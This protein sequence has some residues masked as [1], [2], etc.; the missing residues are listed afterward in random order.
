MSA[1]DQ[2]LPDSFQKMEH[3]LSI[4]Q[5]PFVQIIGVIDKII[6]DAYFSRYLF[7]IFKVKSRT[8]IFSGF[9]G[10]TFPFLF[11]C[12]PFFICAWRGFTLVDFKVAYEFD[13]P[14]HSIKQI[15]HSKTTWVLHV[16]YTYIY[17]FFLLNGQ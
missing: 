7:I 6:L 2:L 10:G 15:L 9:L 13:M 4:S 16:I 5:T 11:C 14:T 1:E 3:K 8:F 17:I 12:R